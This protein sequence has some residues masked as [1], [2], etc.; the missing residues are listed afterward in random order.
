MGQDKGGDILRQEKEAQNLGA[1]L[2]VFS[3]FMF[4]FLNLKMQ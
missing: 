2:G 4:H 3:V 1:C